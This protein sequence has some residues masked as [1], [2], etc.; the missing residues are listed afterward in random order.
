[1]S[2]NS[3]QTAIETEI[4]NYL[5]SKGTPVDSIEFYN[6]PHTK[7]NYLRVGYWNRIADI[8]GISHLVEEDW[9]DDDYRASKFFY[10]I[11]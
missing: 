8:A 4:V 6:D 9:I 11:K 2:K 10:N 5:V 7:M 1:M 3:P